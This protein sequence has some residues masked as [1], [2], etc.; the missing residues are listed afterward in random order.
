[1][2]NSRKLLIAIAIIMIFTLA[3]VAT[4]TQTATALSGTPVDRPVEGDKWTYI[5]SLPVGF[6][7]TA[8]AEYKGEVTLKAEDWNLTED[9]K[10]YYFIMSFEKPKNVAY[11]RFE[12]WQKTYVLENGSTIRA[13]SY[14]L[15]N[16][17]SGGYYSELYFK[18]ISNVSIPLILF[19]L[20][21]GKEWN[22][23]IKTWVIGYSR[24]YSSGSWYNSTFT[25]DNVTAV[26]GFAAGKVINATKVK[27]AAG[28]FEAW[29]INTTAFSPLPQLP[30]AELTMTLAW[31]SPEAKNIVYAECYIFNEISEK[32]ELWN[33]QELT[34]YSVSYPTREAIA[35]VTTF[36]LLQG[37][38]K[39]EMIKFLL[40]VSGWGV[41]IVAT[42]S[43]LYIYR[44]YRQR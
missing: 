32:W 22:V 23:T 38:Q 19:P 11:E 31:F 33:T 7:M 18:I 13:E 34:S 12:A 9:T 8:L 43:A 24:Y 39:A 2:I 40:T 28:E 16:N 30:E 36:M 20:S 27:T 44:R 42:A 25:W 17:M 14:Y 5:T 1:M 10:A 21:E 29:L 26:D 3:T 37:M 35:F 41:A 15:I 4:Q 6:L